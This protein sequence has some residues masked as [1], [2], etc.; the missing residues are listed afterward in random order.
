MLKNNKKIIRMKKKFMCFLIN[1]QF[2]YQ[3]IN[4]K[5]LFQHKLVQKKSFFFNFNNDFYNY[6][7]KFVKKTFL[8]ASS[9]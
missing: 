5:S 6:F 4:K 1:D 7:E 8:K 9:Q 3:K 2:A